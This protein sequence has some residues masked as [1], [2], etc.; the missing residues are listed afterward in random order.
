MK[1]FYANSF[2]TY[3]STPNQLE[4]W[5]DVSHE[6]TLNFCKNSIF[7]NRKRKKK[8]QAGFILHPR[9]QNT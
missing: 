5:A 3:T 7:L 4:F 2:A 8:K 9:T 6:L 1:H